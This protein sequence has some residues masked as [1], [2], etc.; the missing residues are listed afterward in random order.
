[1]R[2]RIEKRIKLVEEFEDQEFQAILK[3]TNRTFRTAVLANAGAWFFY[4]VPIA[5]VCLCFSK[6]KSIAKDALSVPEGELDKVID[7]EPASA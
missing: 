2:S 7:L 3:A 6:L 5:L 1:M 4:I